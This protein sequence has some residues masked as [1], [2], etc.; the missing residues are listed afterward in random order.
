MKLSFCDSR[1]WSSLLASRILP[2]L[3]HVVPLGDAG[4]LGRRLRPAGRSLPA[5]RAGTMT[6]LC[7]IRSVFSKTNSTGLPAR[8]TITSLSYAICS[9]TVPMR[10]TRTPSSPSS[11]RGLLAIGRRQQAGQRV[12]E[13]QR[14]ER[15]RRC[16][17]GGRHLLDRASSN[18]GQQRP[19]RRPWASRSRESAAR[20][21]IAARRSYRRGRTGPAAGTSRLPGRGRASGRSSPRGGSSPPARRRRARTSRSSAGRGHVF[22]L[23]RPR[24]GRCRARGA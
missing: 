4:L 21:R 22:L 15:R 19:A 11:A 14:V 5:S 10:I 16:P 18:D 23:V 13:L 17:V 12:G 3:R 6:K 24:C 8:T 1:G 2:R 20:R 7:G 9:N